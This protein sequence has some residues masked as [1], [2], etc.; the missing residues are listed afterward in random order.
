[1]EFPHF[2]VLGSQSGSAKLNKMIE[3]PAYVFMFRRRPRP[4]AKMMW[5]SHTIIG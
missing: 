2:H 5:R 1:M 3:S 4:H